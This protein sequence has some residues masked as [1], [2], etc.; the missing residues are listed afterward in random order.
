MHHNDR[1]PDPNRTDTATEDAQRRL[2]CV[3][4]DEFMAARAD[5]AARARADG[6]PALAARI[7]AL[8]KPT[9][10]AW[11]VNAFA[12]GDASVVERLVALGAELR[13]AQDGLDPARMR[14]L[15]GD[16]RRLV[17][18]L[19]RAAFRAAGRPDPAIGLRDEVTETLDAAVADPGVARRLGLLQRAEKWSGFGFAPTGG[20]GL[21]LVRGGRDSKRPAARTVPAPKPSAG[22]RRKHQRAVAAARESFAAADTAHDDAQ[23]TEQGLAQRVRTLSARLS[24]LQHELDDAREQLEAA[25]AEVT[26]A[27]GRRRE[28]RSA[29]DRAE[30]DAPG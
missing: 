1:V 17:A 3:P 28:A 25:R 27:R 6:E 30:R 12:T 2:Y 23:A 21:T 5:L 16:R 24:D 13:A 29:L 15:S 22:E 19:A 10:A 18:E 20:P 26:A 7:A 11:I 4:P 9:T 14:E 8:R